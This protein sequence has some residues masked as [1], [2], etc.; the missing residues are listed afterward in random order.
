MAKSDY[1]VVDLESVLARL[2]AALGSPDIALICEA[3]GDAVMLHNVSDIARK[4][5]LERPSLYRAFGDNN[6][7][8]I[9][10]QYL[11]CWTPWV[12]TEGREVA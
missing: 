9:F 6:G 8:Q 7:A 11:T 10:L 3:I 12:S 4:A 5:R 2:N 1:Q